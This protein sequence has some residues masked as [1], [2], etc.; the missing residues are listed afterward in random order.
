MS[1]TTSA[2][3]WSTPLDW[4][5]SGSAG[6]GKQDST[7]IHEAAEQFESLLI[8]QMLTSMR[9]SDGGGWL[10]GGDDQA[11]QTLTEMAE[12]CVAQALATRG[13]FGLAALVEQGLRTAKPAGSAPDPAAS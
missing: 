3:S 12:Q 5:S 13:G 7:R 8:G 6:K 10:G 1:T 2:P 9:Q 4:A 11:G